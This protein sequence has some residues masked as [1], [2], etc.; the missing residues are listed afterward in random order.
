MRFM[1]LALEK[2]REKGTDPA[3]QPIGAVIV[4]DGE[5]I[6]AAHNAVD[7]MKDATAH[8]E[9]CAIREAGAATGDAELDGSTLYSTLQPCGMCTMASIWAGVNRIVFGAGQEQVHEMYFEDRQLGTFDYI[10][11]AYK[12]DLSIEGGVMAD[13][14][15]TLYYGPDDDPPED[16]QGNK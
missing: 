6:A 4:K 1:A 2:A 11:D 14:C 15:A 13:E 7:A 10:R 9:I 12:D 3:C 16:V 8:A 5:V